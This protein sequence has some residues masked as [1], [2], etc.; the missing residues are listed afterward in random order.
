MYKIIEER[1]SFTVLDE[2]NRDIAC[3]SNVNDALTYVP[4]NKK[5]V[6]FRPA[7]VFYNGGKYPHL[8]E[9]QHWPHRFRLSE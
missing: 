4:E 6:L 2:S 1:D 9:P 7:E 8:M 5:A 3:V